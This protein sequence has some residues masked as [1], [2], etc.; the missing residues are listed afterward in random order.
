MNI[1]TDILKSNG[2]IAHYHTS[3]EDINELVDLELQYHEQSREL[4]QLC[5]Y[6]STEAQVIKTYEGNPEMD[7]VAYDLHD[8]PTLKRDANGELVPSKEF[9]VTA[10]IIAAAIAAVALVL[11]IIYKLLSKGSS[12]GGGGKDNKKNTSNGFTITPP[13]DDPPNDLVNMYGE[14]AKVTKA[15]KD[16]SNVTK[17]LKPNCD[18]FTNGYFKKLADKYN[19]SVKNRYDYFFGTFETAQIEKQTALYDTLLARIDEM[20]L[21]ELT[22]IEAIDQVVALEVGQSIEMA[23]LN[24][25]FKTGSEELKSLWAEY[26]LISQ[27]IKQNARNAR[28][29]D[30]ADNSLRDE[31]KQYTDLAIKHC[32]ITYAVAEQCGLCA[33]QLYTIMVKKQNSDNMSPAT[34]AI[35]DAHTIKTKDVMTA[36]KHDMGQLNMKRIKPIAYAHVNYICE[37]TTAYIQKLLI[38]M[39]QG[40]RKYTDDNLSL[41]EFL[42]KIL[43]NPTKEVLNAYCEQFKSDLK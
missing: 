27:Q 25:Q 36:A 37:E 5:T 23:K 17:K 30:R 10:V 34:A 21:S 6:A 12:G 3:V 35:Y 31:L 8:L 24:T 18:A 20:G 41:K 43:K 22:I 26:Q 33:R 2:Q 42:R 38:E 32:K 28:T 14:L 19:N 16:P 9:L 7:S 1:C 40:M 11:Y 4:D 15:K 29:S 39:H 13:P